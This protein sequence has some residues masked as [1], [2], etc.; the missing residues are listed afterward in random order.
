MIFMVCVLFCGLFPPERLL[1]L[2][3]GET[4][5]F[6]GGRRNNTALS[7]SNGTHYQFHM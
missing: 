6:G 2:V 7:N 1:R 4:S 5:F 3:L